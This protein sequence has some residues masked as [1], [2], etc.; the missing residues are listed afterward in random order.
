M[1]GVLMLSKCQ[2]IFPSFP[3]IHFLLNH[4]QRATQIEE[5]QLPQ[6]HADLLLVFLSVGFLSFTIS[7]LKVYATSRSVNQ[8]LFAVLTKQ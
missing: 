3:F 5:A 8:S 2:I 4:F 1:G 7:A 6:N